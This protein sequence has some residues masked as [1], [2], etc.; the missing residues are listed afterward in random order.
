VAS[1]VAYAN[2]NGIDATINVAEGNY[3]DVAGAR[4]TTNIVLK[5][6]S[7]PIRHL[8]AWSWV[9]DTNTRTHS[10]TGSVSVSFGDSRVFWMVAT[11]RA[12][13]LAIQG[14]GSLT[15]TASNGIMLA[16][17]LHH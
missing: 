17:R 16:P 4:A 6:T 1:A 7:L 9:A 8:S 11:G 15:L 2:A 3:A 5:Y 14:S 10:V 13:S 12:S